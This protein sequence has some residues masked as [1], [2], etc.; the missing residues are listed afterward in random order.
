MKRI[1]LAM[2]AAMVVASLVTVVPAATAQISVPPEKMQGTVAYVSGGIGRDEVDAIKHVAAQYALELEFARKAI[3]RDE[4]VS[5][6]KVLIKN[7]EGKPVLDTTSDGPLLLA[8]LP[9]GIYSVSV[10]RHG[11]TIQRVV[12]IKA[13]KHARLIFVWTK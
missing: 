9:T 6:V 11:D 2:G 3:P 8:K 10:D 12:Q 5:D 1:T 13:D 4:Y 7:Q